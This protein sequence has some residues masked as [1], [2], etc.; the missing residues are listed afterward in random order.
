MKN[1]IRMDFYRLFHSKALKV[2]II[3][4]FLVAIAASLFNYGI[5]EL[6]K[7]TMDTD[8]EG[9]ESIGL[10]IPAVGWIAGVD[11]SDIMI[12]GTGAFSLLISC[13]AAASFIR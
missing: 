5:V 6:I 1:L 10:I 11:F 8:P 7:M 9:A 3:A 4:A 13:I 12:N 2:G